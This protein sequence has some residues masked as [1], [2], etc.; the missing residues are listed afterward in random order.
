MRNERLI[1]SLIK[2]DL[3]NCKLVDG[4]NSLGLKADDYCLYLSDTIFKLIGFEDND[5]TEMIHRYYIN[6][7]KKVKELEITNVD[8]SID[9]LANEIYKSLKEKV[10]LQ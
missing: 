4:L 6:Q 5:K 3:I 9:N 8:K 1:I 7:T 10:K 2:D